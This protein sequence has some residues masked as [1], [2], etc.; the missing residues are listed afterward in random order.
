[1]ICEWCDKFTRFSPHNPT[2]SST[3]PLRVLRSLAQM[4]LPESKLFCMLSTEFHRLT[5]HFMIVLLIILFFFIFHWVRLF[6][7]QFGFRSGSL[8]NFQLFEMTFLVRALRL[9]SNRR[10]EKR[11]KTR[12]DS[13]DQSCIKKYSPVVR[14]SRWIYW[15][16]GK[17]RTRRWTRSTSRW[18]QDWSTGV[19]NNL[20]SPTRLS[21]LHPRDEHIPP[22]PACFPLDRTMFLVQSH[23]IKCVKSHSQIT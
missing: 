15:N 17:C 7:R 22:V 16:R 2:I 4:A 6:G 12:E 5:P 8:F 20:H 23:D 9:F 21:S 10:V 13:P 1:M 18:S 19:N 3:I 14:W 11:W